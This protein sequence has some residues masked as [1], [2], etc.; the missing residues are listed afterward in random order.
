MVSKAKRALV[1]LAR[2]AAVLQ[3]PAAALAAGPPE[4]LIGQPFPFSNLPSVDSVNVAV[5]HSPGDNRFLVV[6][7]R[8][9]A[10]G[11]LD[12]L[13]LLERGPGGLI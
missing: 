3:L 13:S 4:P 5:A 8:L 6:H 2:L 1:L 10:A 7:A 9:Y 12:A 11:I